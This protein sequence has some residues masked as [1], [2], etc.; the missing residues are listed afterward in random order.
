MS[1]PILSSET[2]HV[3]TVAIGGRAVLIGGRSGQGKSD[4]ALRLI[5]RGAALVSDDY[6][7]VRRAGEKLLA[8]APANIAGKI[9]VRGVGLIDS[10]CESDVPVALFVDLDNEPE[11]LPEPGS[12]L[13]VAG[14]AV[15]VVALSALE[16]SAPIKVEAALK[17]FGLS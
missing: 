3:S 10:P 14:I 13:S 9:E 5:D 16:A 6:T 4:L 17:Q 11:R 7:H 2:L 12:T 1:Q 15:P 8:S